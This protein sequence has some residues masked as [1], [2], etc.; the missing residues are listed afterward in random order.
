MVKNGFLVVVCYGIVRAT[1]APRTSEQDIQV[2]I[3]LA[4]SRSGDDPQAAACYMTAA[5]L[6]DML[7]DR[8]APRCILTRRRLEKRDGY[9]FHFTSRLPSDE[10]VKVK[11]LWTTDAARTFLDLCGEEPHLAPWAYR[12]AVRNGVLERAQ[13]EERI[14]K[15]ARQGRSGIVLAR[16]ILEGTSDTAASAKSGLEDRYHD[17]LV[18]AGYPPPQRNV[19]LPGSYGHPWEVDLYYPQVRRGIEISPYLTH[20]SPEVHVR[21]GR[22]ENDLEGQ[23][24][25]LTRITEDD[26]TFERFVEQIR[27]I[28][29][30]PWDFPCR[31]VV[32]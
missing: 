27:P 5:V 2:G 8:G 1:G 7:D 21:D 24:I 4:S 13:I 10:L 17:F 6:H 32:A 28:L 26:L 12:R 16:T 19:K 18:R 22:K 15:E 31:E 11:G 9:S 14:G 30:P 25:R 20:S 23:G 3:L 29:G